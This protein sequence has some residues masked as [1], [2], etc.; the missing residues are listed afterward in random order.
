MTE[1]ITKVNAYNLHTLKAHWSSHTNRG[2]FKNVKGTGVHAGVHFQKCSNIGINI[3]FTFLP[4][5]GIPGPQGSRK[6]ASAHSLNKRLGTQQSWINNTGVC[7]EELRV[8]NHKFIKCLLIVPKILIVI[9]S[10]PTQLC[11]NFTGKS[12]TSLQ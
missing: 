10:F 9:V 1:K 5:S 2:V 4:P 8:I 6:Y 7:T 12:G 11:K 3:F